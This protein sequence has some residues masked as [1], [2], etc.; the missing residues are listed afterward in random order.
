MRGGDRRGRRRRWSA[1]AHRTQRVAR[2]C[3]TSAC[4]W[5]W[6]YMP[7]PTPSSRTSPPAAPAPDAESKP[8]RR[9]AR[10]ARART[11]GRRALATALRANARLGADSPPAVD[12]PASYGRSTEPGSSTVISGLRCVPVP[13]ARAPATRGIP[14]SPLAGAPLASPSIPSLTAPRRANAAEP[15]SCGVS[16]SACRCRP[17][18]PRRSLSGAHLS[19]QGARRRPRRDGASPSHPTTRSRALTTFGSNCVPPHRCSSSRASSIGI[20]ARYGRSVV[21]AL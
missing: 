21:I 14:V 13:I 20:A 8:F 9:S 15:G 1:A 4:P 6:R 16:R 18:D 10:R 17:V 3:A 11:R 5:R 7:P 12:N 19:M 2:H